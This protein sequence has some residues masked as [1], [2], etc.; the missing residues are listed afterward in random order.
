MC[1]IPLGSQN[2][3][4]QS[5]KHPS[6]DLMLKAERQCADVALTAQ[7][8]CAVDVS[9]A[10]DSRAAYAHVYW[11]HGHFRRRGTI[12]HESRSQDREQ[13]I[14]FLKQWPSTRRKPLNI[15]NYAHYI[16]PGNS[17]EAQ[18]RTPLH[19]A[20]CSAKMRQMQLL[21]FVMFTI[22][23]VVTASPWVQIYF[24]GQRSALCYYFN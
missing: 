8:Q 14:P 6:H 22:F 5:S 17:Q 15:A 2:L 12:V 13:P 1:W 7:A 9:R 19:Q 20:V 4:K 18:H 24:L 21:V 10:S 16:K 23:A 3:T 11:F